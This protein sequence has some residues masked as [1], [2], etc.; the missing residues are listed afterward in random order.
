VLPL[1]VTVALPAVDAFVMPPAVPPLLVIF[2]LLAVDVEK[3]LEV[4]A[5]WIRKVA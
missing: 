3:L 2:A 4:P 1:L 5:L